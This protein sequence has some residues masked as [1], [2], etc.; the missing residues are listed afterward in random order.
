MV[1]MA[2]IETASEDPS[3]PLSTGLSAGLRFPLPHDPQRSYG[4]GSF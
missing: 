3:A 2:V 4:F 1:E